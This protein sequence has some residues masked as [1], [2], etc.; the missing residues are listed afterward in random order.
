MRAKFDSSEQ[1]VELEFND[2]LYTVLPILFR[3]SQVQYP[4]KIIRS[5]VALFL[6]TIQKPKKR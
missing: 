1:R 2:S 6:A 3:I 4:L 5:E